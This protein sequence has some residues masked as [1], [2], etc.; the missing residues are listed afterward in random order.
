MTLRSLVVASDGAKRYP[1]W[2]PSLFSSLLF[3]PSL[4][5]ATFMQC[6]SAKSPCSACLIFGEIHVLGAG[7]TAS[8]VGS[9]SMWLDP[10]CHHWVLRWGGFIPRGGRPLLDPA[11]IFTLPT[12]GQRTTDEI[13]TGPIGS[14][15][16]LVGSP[17]GQPDM[18]CHRWYPL[19]G[20]L[21]L[22]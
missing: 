9:S 21:L 14:L 22:H 4:P 2:P 10:S 17:Q 5:E 7:S 16:Q 1:S 8:P 3:L 19:G 15:S 13:S 6:T 12:Q 20:A 11:T 18:S